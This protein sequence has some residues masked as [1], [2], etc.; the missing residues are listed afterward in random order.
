MRAHS[1]PPCSRPSGQWRGPLQRKRPLRAG[2]L[3][4]REERNGTYARAR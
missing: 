2:R 3:T 4:L 1:S